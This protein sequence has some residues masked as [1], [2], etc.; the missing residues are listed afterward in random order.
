MAMS[1]EKPELSMR[2]LVWTHVVTY[3]NNVCKVLYA[4]KK[5]QT[6]RRT[7]YFTFYIQQILH[8][9]LNACVINNLR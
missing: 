8:A 7:E 2:H 4:Y 6:L 3:Q 5:L 9:L 1:V